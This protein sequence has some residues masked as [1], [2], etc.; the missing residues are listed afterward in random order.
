MQKSSIPLILHIS[1]NLHRTIIHLNPFQILL[2]TL[3]PSTFMNNRFLIQ[4]TW[5]LSIYSMK[6]KALEQAD[7]IHRLR[8]TY[9]K[10]NSHHIIPIHR[11]K[12][13]L[14]LRH[15]ISMLCRTKKILQHVP[16]NS[17]SMVSIIF[18]FIL[19]KK[20]IIMMITISTCYL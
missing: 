16:K 20:S 12:T 10:Y 4:R 11:P 5:F 19:S 2:L 3:F 8:K 18:P 13:I 6:K 15:F 1:M 7:Y 9:F 14:L 17:T